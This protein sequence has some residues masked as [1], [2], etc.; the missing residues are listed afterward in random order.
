[1]LLDLKS[2][3]TS[4]NDMILVYK[5]STSSLFLTLGLY[6]YLPYACGVLLHVVLPKTFDFVEDS[7]NKPNMLT[8]D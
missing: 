6:L 5:L 4:S 1:M 2:L 7:F 3:L 8:Q